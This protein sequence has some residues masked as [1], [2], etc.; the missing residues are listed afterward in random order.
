MRAANDSS[1]RNQLQGTKHPRNANGPDPEKKEKK[2]TSS[3]AANEKELRELIDNN[4]H[5]SLE[6][7]S[8]DVRGAEKT[9]KSEKAKQLFAMRW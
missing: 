5:R 7:I 1:A 3:T 2:S 8:K 4:W 9:Q 6:S